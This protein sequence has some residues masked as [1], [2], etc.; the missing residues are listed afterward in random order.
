MYIDAEHANPTC[1]KKI[2]DEFAEIVK[3][4]GGK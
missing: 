1:L 4:E 3:S 2:F